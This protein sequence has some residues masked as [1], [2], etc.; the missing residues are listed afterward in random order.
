MTFLLCCIISTVYHGRPLK[1][2]LH[3]VYIIVTKTFIKLENISIYP[4]D[5][6]SLLC[7]LHA[8]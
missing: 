8:S 7:S 4:F 3:S 6:F 1:N 2:H 5:Y